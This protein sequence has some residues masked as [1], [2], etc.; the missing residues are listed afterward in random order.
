MTDLLEIP[1]FLKR[2]ITSGAARRKYKTRTKWQMPKL[3]F[4]KRPPRTKTFSGAQRVFVHLTNEANSIGSGRR[5]V[6]AKSGR[7][8]VYL[9]DNMGNRGRLLLPDFHKVMKGGN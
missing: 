7:K 2:E 8:W 4:E 9:C 6:W 5:K 3:P 1:S